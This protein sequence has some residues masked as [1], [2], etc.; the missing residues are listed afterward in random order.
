M[1]E[2]L[3]KFYDLDIP[4][5]N[6]EMEKLDHDNINSLMIEGRIASAYWSE[7]SKIFNLL[8]SDFNFQSRK[9]LS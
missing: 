5:I 2:Q 4:T 1:L 6:K 7:I 9:N 8:A 3:S